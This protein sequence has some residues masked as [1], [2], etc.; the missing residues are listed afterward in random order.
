MRWG[1]HFQ[2][3]CIVNIIKSDK[4]L[5]DLQRATILLKKDVR[6]QNIYPSTVGQLSALITEFFL[7]VVNSDM[8]IGHYAWYM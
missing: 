5:H 1:F 7:S 2:D 4:E 3:C 6:G 8:V